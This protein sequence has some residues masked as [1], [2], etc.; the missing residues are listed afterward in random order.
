V[1]KIG[2]VICVAALLVTTAI[3]AMA[4][5]T[6]WCMTLRAGYYSGSTLT[7]GSD[8]V[9]G[10]KD[11]ASQGPIHTWDSSRA[12]LAVG[13]GGYN[14]TS[15][16]LP[17]DTVPPVLYTYHVTL[18]V[19]A[20]YSSGLVYIT[21]WCGNKYGSLTGYDMP[22][23]YTITVKMNGQALVT[24]GRND[25]WV[26]DNTPAGNA[27]GPMGFWYIYS[28]RVGSFAESV[29]DFTVEIGP[30]AQTPEPGGLVALASGLV[31]MAGFAIRR[32]KTA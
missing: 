20:T 23:N 9:L 31:G 5:D 16:W 4:S 10:V 17:V 21:G 11:G 15:Q 19:G 7:Y 24:L 25:L 26:G 6:Q 27:A 3:A 13:D 32:R 30:S 12:N 8:V 28:S 14:G 18:G 22:E 2:L 1:K 29:D